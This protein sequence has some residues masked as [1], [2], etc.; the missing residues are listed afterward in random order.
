[1]ATATWV[2]V[3]SRQ[4]THVSNGDEIHLVLYCVTVAVAVAGIA[5]WTNACVLTRMDAVSNG[6]VS[7][8]PSTKWLRKER[9][10]SK[11][12]SL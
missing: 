8:M 10:G 9:R 4:G 3:L 12:L 7:G 2:C 1:M 6:T 5:G 11:W